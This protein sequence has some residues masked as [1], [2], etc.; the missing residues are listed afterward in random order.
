MLST[1]ML[2]VVMLSIIML[3]VVMLSVIMLSVEALQNM[4]L[5]LGSVHK[6]D[7]ANS[8]KTSTLVIGGVEYKT[9]PSMH[10]CPC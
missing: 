8:I 5:A 6:E 1:I 10:G 3:S 7:G 2:S 9:G 4:L